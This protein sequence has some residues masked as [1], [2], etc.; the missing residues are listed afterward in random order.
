MKRK[1]FKAPSTACHRRQRRGARKKQKISS[2][3]RDL[4]LVLEV[5][6]DNKD[7][8]T[9]YVVIEGN[10]D[11][12]QLYDFR[13]A[14]VVRHYNL[15]KR[16]QL[17]TRIE[18]WENKGYEIWTGDKSEAQPDKFYAVLEPG[19]DHFLR[20]IIVVNS[21]EEDEIMEGLCEAIPW[22][23]MVDSIGRKAAGRGRQQKRSDARANLRLDIGLS[24]RNSR[25]G[26]AIPGMNVP[27]RIVAPHRHVE[28]HDGDKD[29]EV[30]V[31]KS[32]C[33]VVAISDYVGKKFHWKIH[34]SMRGP[35][36]EGDDQ[37]YRTFAGRWWE[38]MEEVMA[39][40]DKLFKKLARFEGSSVIATGEVVKDVL[41]KTEPHVDSSNGR[42][43]G[44]DRTPTL[45]KIVLIRMEDGTTREVRVC[46]NVYG[47][48]ECEC[49]LMR[50]AYLVA[51]SEFVSQS[52][53]RYEEEWPTV[54]LCAKFDPPTNGEEV[55]EEA[56][57]PTAWAIRADNDKSGYY[58]L[59]AN[60]LRRISELTGG[61]RSIMVEALY[62]MHLTPCPITWF[63]CMQKTMDIMVGMKE[64]RGEWF[65]LVQVFVR[66]R[67][68][69]DEGVGCGRY[70][71][72]QPSAKE[73]AESDLMMS[74]RNLN[75]ILESMCDP[76]NLDTEG[77][78]RRMNKR[79]MDGG[80][81]NIGAFHACAIVHVAT[82]C[83]L[84]TVT[85]HVERVVIAKSTATAKK[86]MEILRGRYPDVERDKKWDTMMKDLVPFVAEYLGVTN[87][88]AEN[89][90]CE[91]LR[92]ESVPPIIK[93]DVFVDGH[94]LLVVESDG[95]KEISITGGRQKVENNVNYNDWY[96]PRIRWWEEDEGSPALLIALRRREE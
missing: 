3:A 39:D 85:E 49:A 12:A 62:T 22:E 6:Y 80:C 60:E 44:Y 32:G 45:T 47:K 15:S 70:L 72:C 89:S 55:F 8:V 48:Y 31:Y 23:W 1:K 21:V 2:Y 25:D 33:A 66:Q 95:V 17:Q 24:G 82:M 7:R 26:V 29:Q 38:E 86:L 96:D 77:F 90:I 79:P 59:F 36:F 71:R 76:L 53:R 93:Y 30:T 16:F 74:C 87:C 46:V 28:G 4:V 5:R 40:E 73:L 64:G 81:A 20:D 42:A 41:M 27:A 57:L 9:G 92:R 51:I 83:G 34:E 11:R 88:M 14:D 56:G 10:G 54:P 43:E 65:N 94:K 75:E 58:S 61:N 37:R 50:R 52:M 63:R 78:I 68:I 13:R 35:A 19:R 91:A 18:S 67:L 84:V 69:S